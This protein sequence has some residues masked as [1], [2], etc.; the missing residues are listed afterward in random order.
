MPLILHPCI[1]TASTLKNMLALVFLVRWLW[2]HT[3]TRVTPLTPVT[4]GGVAGGG[5][6]R[7][8]TSS[9]S[10]W[11]VCGRGCVGGSMKVCGKSVQIVFGVY[12]TRVLKLSA[13]HQQ[14]LTL[15]SSSNKRR[16]IQL[17]WKEYYCQSLHK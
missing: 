12:H 1:V 16:C 10:T 17:I 2:I 5:G 11:Y 7:A 4:R 14:E 9:G 6:R 15:Q 3:L 13:F 8:C